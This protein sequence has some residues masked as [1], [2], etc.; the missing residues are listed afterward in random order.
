MEKEEKECATCG[1]IGYHSPKCPNFE[2]VGGGSINKKKEELELKR[3]ELDIQRIEKETKALDNPVMPQISPFEQ[4]LAFMKQ[5]D[6][7]VDRKINQRE[8][9]RDSIAGFAEEENGSF[10]EKLGLKVLDMWA[11]GALGRVSAK[12][13][14]PITAPGLEPQAPPVNDMNK[15]KLPTAEEFE[16]YK[17][18]IKAGEISL[19]DAW[20]DFVANYP[21][22]N[23]SKEKFAEEFE[24]IK[25]SE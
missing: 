6:E 12:T 18:S 9:I 15:P 24:K 10:E 13:I 1:L 20:G 11:N 16:Q 25:T 14:S 17:K 8:A 4:A 22:L 5:M 3:L 23:I 7:M 19:E 2:H 21:K